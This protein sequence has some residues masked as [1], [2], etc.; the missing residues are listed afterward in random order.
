M[1]S[2]PIYKSRS[3]GNFST[4]DTGGAG[5]SDGGGDASAMSMSDHSYPRLVDDDDATLALALALQDTIEEKDSSCPASFDGD[6]SNGNGGVVVK[7]RG[8]LVLESD[9]DAGDDEPS[10]P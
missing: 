2:S 10:S 4:E 1:T 3:L 5:G 7:F 6:D 9:G 8:A